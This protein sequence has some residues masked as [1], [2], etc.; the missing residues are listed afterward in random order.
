LPSVPS[1]PH[2]YC[3]ISR[4]A[5]AFRPRPSGKFD[6]PPR[7]SH[8]DSVFC[9][10]AYIEAV[11]QGFAVLKASPVVVLKHETSTFR[12]SLYFISIDLTFGVGD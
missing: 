2:W 7:N 4:I 5:D 1:I 9:S 3:K 10:L 8:F 12:Q 6:N 11:W